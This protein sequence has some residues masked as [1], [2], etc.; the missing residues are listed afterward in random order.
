MRAAV[1]AE[2]DRATNGVHNTWYALGA[3]STYA[4]F[5]ESP[6]EAIEH[7]VLLGA[8]LAGEFLVQP[9]SASDGRDV[10]PGEGERKA[11]REQ[12]P[13][14]DGHHEHAG[15]LTAACGSRQLRSAGSDLA[16]WPS[17]RLGGNYRRL[18]AY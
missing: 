15:G 13:G 11:R 14:W 2:C 5:L 1:V 17:R 7:G 10:M 16:Q 12:A 9:E 3:V 18:L 8:V 4:L 6:D